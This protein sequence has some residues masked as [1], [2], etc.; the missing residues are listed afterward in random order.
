MLA[1]KALF[2]TRKLVINTN[3][4][5]TH[6]N[7]CLGTCLELSA[8]TALVPQ[9]RHSKVTFRKTLPYTN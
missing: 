2:G 3:T 9:A 7:H 1:L 6:S 8:P 5:G 4:Q